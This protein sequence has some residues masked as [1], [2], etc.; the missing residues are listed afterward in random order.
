MAI[1]YK[2][3]P[4]LSDGTNY[5]VVDTPE[6]VLEVVKTW[7]EESKRNE[8]CQ[9]ETIEMSDEEADALPEI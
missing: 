9:I 4:E 2:L 6:I 7:L 1:R 5:T 8:S 3:S